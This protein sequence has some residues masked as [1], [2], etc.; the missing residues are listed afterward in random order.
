MDGLPYSLQRRRECDEALS[1]GL[2][3]RRRFLL[4]MADMPGAWRV[5]TFI[6]FAQDDL[7][8]TRCGERK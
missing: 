3:A 4:I 2:P 7:G 1:P 6:P 8:A 5:I